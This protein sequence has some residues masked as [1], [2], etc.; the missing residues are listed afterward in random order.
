MTATKNPKRN[1]VRTIAATFAV[2]ALVLLILA[3]ANSRDPQAKADAQ[4]TSYL[5]L[6]NFYNQGSSPG[7]F[8][9]SALN[10]AAD[11][12]PGVTI[13]SYTAKR[14]VLRVLIQGGTFQ[15]CVN[16]S[17]VRS[18]LFCQSPSS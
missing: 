5:T 9:E 8:T 4:A 18:S 10:K 7:A 17:P 11:S 1:Q 15:V 2:V 16:T 13:E 14:T 3:V 6:V 12:Y